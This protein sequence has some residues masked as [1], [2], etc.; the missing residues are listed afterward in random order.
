MGSDGMGLRPSHI[1]EV[2]VVARSE[3]VG[4]A[5]W[6][7]IHRAALLW[8]HEVILRRSAFEHSSEWRNVCRR[9]LRIRLERHRCR[10][11]RLGKPR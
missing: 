5:G 7:C 9:W 10:P 6:G 4:N 3:R 2:T 1:R 11:A 8:R